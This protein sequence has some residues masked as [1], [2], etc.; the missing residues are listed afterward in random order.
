MRS[1]LSI[2]IVLAVAAAAAR[3]QNEAPFRD[4]FETSELGDWQLS[5]GLTVAAEDI[6]PTE[7]KGSWRLEKEP[8]ISAISPRVIT[9]RIDASPFRGKTVRLSADLR[10]PVLAERTS[11]WLAMRSE[12]PGHQAGFSD[13]D[14]AFPVKSAEWTRAEMIADITRDAQSIEI[15]IVHQGDE[16]AWVD[17]LRL[18][19]VGDRDL[20]KSWRARISER[21]FMQT[22]VDLVRVRSEKLSSFFGRE[23]MMEASVLTPAD[24]DGA[25]ALPVCYL[26]H[27]FGGDNWSIFKQASSWRE[28]IASGEYARLI[29]V[30][31]DARCGLGHHVFADSVNNGPR[32]AALVKE[33]IPALESAFGGPRDASQR[34]L[35]GHSSGGWATLWLQ[36]N[37]PET[38]G[39]TW[40]TAPDPID[41]RDFSGV[42]IYDETNAYRDAG[43]D[44]R[45]LVRVG[46]QVIRTMEAFVRGEVLRSPVGGQMASFDAVF[47]PRGEL[48]QAQPLFD[49][50]TGAIDPAVAQAW[51]RYDIGFI[52]RNRWEELEPKLAGKLHVWTGAEDTFYLE[53]AVRLVKADLEAR[54]AAAD[55]LIVPG[56]D[57]GN[58]FQPHEKHWPQGLRARVFREMAEAAARPVAAAD[59]EL[60]DLFADIDAALDSV[61]LK[62]V[63][64]EDHAG[65]CG[66]GHDHGPGG[67]THA[68]DTPPAANSSAKK[69]E[70]KKN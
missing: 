46:G 42:D 51:S 59:D 33:L 14:D 15:A 66:C 62:T 22:P 50:E 4:G 35:T 70:G 24:W 28:K 3:G 25:E 10:V 18:E 47:S 53:G 58:L 23:V 43:G 55:F 31:L 52:L 40:S 26:I 32:G 19:I 44:D 54:E 9:R 30:F 57:H 34:F 21:R 17:D 60:G 64:Q 45:P 49:R 1:L 38:F 20:E 7:G 68:H 39:G 37:Y 61:E 11:I 16:P 8:Q 56:R 67:H 6:L 5:R 29:Y 48:G 63:S 36:V 2:G 12:R 41:F 27:G 65:D 69:N 13:A